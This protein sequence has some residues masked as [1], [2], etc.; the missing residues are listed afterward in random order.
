[1]TRIL[2]HSSEDPPESWYALL[3]A[4]RPELTFAVYR[5]G[6]ALAGWPYLLCNAP[7]PGLIAAMP[8]LKGVI[9]LFAGIEH[10]PQAELPYGV[11]LVRM[12][13]RELIQGM[14]QYVALHALKYARDL[15]GYRRIA[16]E[17]AWRVLP[18]RQARIGI[19]GAGSLGTA[20]GAALVTLGCD[21]AGWRRHRSE[22]APF[23]LYIGEP[24]RERFLRRTDILVCLLPLTDETT[25]VIDA[26]LLAQL[27][28]GSYLVN[29]ARGGHVVD[30]DLLAALAT[31]QIAGATLDVFREE[32]LPT[33]HPL[34]GD[35][36][37]E[38]TPH[39]AAISFPTADAARHVLVAIDA[40]E[41]GR[42]L[43][44]Q[45]DREHGY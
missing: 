41:A 7:P 20:A 3:A 13:S 11:P 38:I 9:S 6:M 35:P 45:V 24:E 42:A 5:S 33:D 10:V 14:A 23:T 18:Q 31:G 43:T 37:I 32:P 29:V 26:A 27:P 28:R 15:D 34:R 36:R 1:M 12:A 8:D 19:L 22:D 21:V 16:A 17:R 40:I 25:G 39:V 30:A 4:A 44:H 2:F